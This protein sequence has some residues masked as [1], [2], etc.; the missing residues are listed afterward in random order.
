MKFAV[1]SL[2][3]CDS[4]FGTLEHV[5]KESGIDYVIL[6]IDLDSGCCEAV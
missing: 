6:G 2:V 3:T 1:L 5:I 4:H